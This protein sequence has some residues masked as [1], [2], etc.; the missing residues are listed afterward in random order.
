ML[1]L[2]AS[3]VIEQAQKNADELKALELEFLND[4]CKKL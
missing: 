2:K 4:K 3:E 1:G